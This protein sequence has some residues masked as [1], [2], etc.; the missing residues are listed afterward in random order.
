MADAPNYPKIAQLRDVPAL[1]GRLEELGLP[2]PIDDAVL[3]A[4][5]GSPLAAADRRRRTSRSAIAG[6]SMRWKA[7]TPTPTAR[8]ASTRCGG[9]ET[10]AAAGRS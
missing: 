3:S 10:S 4:A 5:D 8:R 6:A 1:R 7:G 2:L 9:G